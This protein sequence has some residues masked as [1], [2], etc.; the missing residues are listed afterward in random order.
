MNSAEQLAENRRRDAERIAK[1]QAIKQYALWHAQHRA[2]YPA[3][4]KP[5]DKIYEISQGTTAPFAIADEFAQENITVLIFTS[6]IPSHPHTWVLDNVYDSIRA[7]LPKAKIIVLADGVDGSEPKSYTIFKQAVRQSGKD[8]IAFHG[9]HHQTLMLRFALIAGII[10]TPLVMVGEHDWGIYKLFIDWLKIA[11]VL[12]DFSCPFKLIQVRQAAI[13]QWEID[14]K[15]FGSL[16]NFDGID[17]LSSSC[18]QAPIHI[19]NCEWYRPL[20]AKC[21][22]PDFL[23]RAELG[24]IFIHTGAI[25]EMAAYIPAGPMGRLYHLNGRDVRHPSQIQ[26]LDVPAFKNHHLISFA[27]G[28]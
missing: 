21:S 13:G 10:K 8:M 15:Y 16:F 7:Q 24:N 22:Q 14:N 19:A 2:A 27:K 5:P 1:E 20:I 6:P 4:V 17:L 25:K 18:F 12:L 11:H 26:G 28:N 9:R 3:F 23:E